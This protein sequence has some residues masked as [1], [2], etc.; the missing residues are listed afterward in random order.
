MIVN[1]SGR[2]WTIFWMP[3][4]FYTNPWYI[5][6]G[7]GSIPSIG[8]HPAMHPCWKTESPKYRQ[9]LKLARSH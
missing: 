9:H 7:K 4:Y 5:L 3:S 2:A 6:S 1:A 8:I